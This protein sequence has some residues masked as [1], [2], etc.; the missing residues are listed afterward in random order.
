MLGLL[1]SCMTSASAQTLLYPG[2]PAPDFPPGPF[3]DGR[4]HKISDYQDKVLVLFF[5][6]SFH[7][8]PLPGIRSRSC[9][10]IVKSFQGKP[11][12]F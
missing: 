9:T 4:Q 12:K 8:S 7:M 11:V 6:E 3:T 2:T 10:A 5:F 1:L